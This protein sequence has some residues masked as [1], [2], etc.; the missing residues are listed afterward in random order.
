MSRG[1]RLAVDFVL[2]Q[3]PKPY[4]SRKLFLEYIETIFLPYLKELQ[5][6]EELEAC[7]AVL[8]MDNCSSHVSDDIVAVVT[9]AQVRI[10]TFALTRLTS[11]KCL[12]WSYLVP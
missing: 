9:D 7:E 5:D 1:A 8:R 4:V 12:M 3:W 6:S 10:V 11:S 2:R